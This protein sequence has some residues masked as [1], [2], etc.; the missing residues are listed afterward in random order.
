MIVHF[1]LNSSV[2][3]IGNV[4]SLVGT[5]LLLAIS[6]EKL[7]RR[8]ASKQRQTARRRPG[9]HRGASEAR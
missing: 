8:R 2:A 6:L 1:A 7:R 9:D 4:I 5:G 3:L